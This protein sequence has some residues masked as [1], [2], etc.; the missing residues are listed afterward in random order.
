M[1]AGMSGWNGVCKLR[2]PLK[3]WHGLMGQAQTC[4]VFE[5]D[6]DLLCPAV[7]DFSIRAL[8]NP[9]ILVQVFLRQIILPWATLRNAPGRLQEEKFCRSRHYA[10]LM[11][12]RRQ[13][14]Y[15]GGT[16]L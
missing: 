5:F 14:L 11:S 16:A 3:F 2:R 8:M 10:V 12:F 15:Y 13:T 6:H 9:V 1:L 7:E 4:G